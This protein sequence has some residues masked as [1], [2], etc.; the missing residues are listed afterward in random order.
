VP[1]TAAGTVDVSNPFLENMA[2]NKFTNPAATPATEVE[3]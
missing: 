2:E 3:P 1:L